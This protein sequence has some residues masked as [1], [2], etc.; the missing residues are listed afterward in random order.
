MVEFLI[1]GV[2]TMELIPRIKEMRMEAH[3]NQMQLAKKINMS[4]SQLSEIERGKNYP[5][6]PTLWKIAKGIGCLV[7]DLYE[8]SN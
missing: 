1:I 3:M 2:I 6:A 7:D 5:S 4:K 8:V